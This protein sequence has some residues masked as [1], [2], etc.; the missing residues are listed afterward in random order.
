MMAKSY[1]ELRATS[2]E[3]LIDDYDRIATN[4]NVGLDFIRQEIAR[5]EQ[6]KETRTI[7]R[8]TWVITF[9]TLANAVLVGVTLTR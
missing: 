5:R 6:A 3:R 9:L 4:T 7:V 1:R 2:I 8:L